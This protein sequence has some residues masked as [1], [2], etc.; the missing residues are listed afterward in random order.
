ML[1]P[2]TSF[3][4]ALFAAFA[5]VPATAIGSVDVALLLAIDISDSID[6]RELELQR[7]GYVKALTSPGV[8]RAIKSGR[9]QRIAISYVEWGEKGRQTVV[10]DW[11]VIEDSRSAHAFSAKIEEAPFHVDRYT[12]IASLLRFAVGHLERCPCESLRTIVDISGDGPNNQ[13]GSVAKARDDLVARGVIVNGLPLMLAPQVY[14]WR[15]ITNISEYY[16]DCVI[17]GPGAFVIPVTDMREFADAIKLKLILE[18]GGYG[19]GQAKQLTAFLQGL[20]HNGRHEPESG[21]TGTGSGLAPFVRPAADR[22]RI[23]CELYD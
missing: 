15:G 13:G 17:G 5:P 14:H 8:L 10:A 2:F 9:F 4:V 18:I 7:E 6:E 1:R 21:V 11:Q 22:G 20:P 16:G 23:R 12:S 19:Q 3:A